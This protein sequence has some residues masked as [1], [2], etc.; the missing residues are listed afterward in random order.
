MR[1]NASCDSEGLF[2]PVMILISMRMPVATGQIPHKSSPHR[3]TV[4][5]GSAGRLG[6]V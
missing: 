4:P 1:T 5:G 6:G 3:G 2:L